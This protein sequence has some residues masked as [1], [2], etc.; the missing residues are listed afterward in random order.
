MSGFMSGGG[1][2]IGGKMETG[3]DV[4]QSRVFNPSRTRD[5][6]FNETESDQPHAIGAMRAIMKN[7]VAATPQPMPRAMPSK[8]RSMTRPH[9]LGQRNCSMFVLLS[10]QSQSIRLGHDISPFMRCG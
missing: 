5:R 4:V 6:P 2:M 10:R 9:C 8:N 7:I 3:R 1:S